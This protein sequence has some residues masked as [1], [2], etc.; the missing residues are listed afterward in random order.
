L[1]LYQRQRVQMPFY[2]A[3]Q[4]SCRTASET[5]SFSLVCHRRRLSVRLLHLSALTERRSTT[6]P[7]L[8]RSISSSCDNPHNTLPTS[9]S[10]LEGYPKLEQALPSPS[11]P[12]ALPVAQEAPASGVST[13]AGWRDARGSGTAQSTRGFPDP[14]APDCYTRQ[15]PNQPHISREREEIPHMNCGGG[16]MDCLICSCLTGLCFRSN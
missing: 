16:G 1:V 9:T 6:A 11:P 5:A 8:T 4:C 3:E 13:E 7:S 12:P 15:H 14:Y 2:Q 10:S